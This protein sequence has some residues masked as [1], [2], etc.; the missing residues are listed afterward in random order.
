M[1]I[2]EQIIEA[3]KTFLG[4]PYKKLD[5]SAFVRAVF[6]KFDYELPRTSVEQA[7]F[8]YNKK[9]TIAIDKTEPIKNILPELKKAM[10]CFWWS[11]AHPE[12][13]KGIH[14]VSIYD[15]NGYNYESSS[16]AGKVVRRKLWEN[17]DWQIVFIADITSLLKAQEVT[18]EM[19]RY[20]EKTPRVFNAEEQA[21]QEAL[22]SLGY[23]LPKDGADGKFGPETLTAFNQFQADNKVPL[24]KEYDT[25]T[26]AA[27]M[28]AQ[29]KKAEDAKG[30]YAA[31]SKDYDTYASG[32]IAA[33][34]MK[35]RI[36]T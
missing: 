7:K 27:M 20:Q 16:S 17:S 25:A 18:E 14:H 26:Q 5:C 12:R 33:A 31:L 22:L 11:K 24:S 1:D 21:L 35:R 9:L 28:R 32:C 3:A 19:I 2:R 8:L 13:W 36:F 6:R 34:N 29:A 15:E 10:L 23:A 30:D 4:T